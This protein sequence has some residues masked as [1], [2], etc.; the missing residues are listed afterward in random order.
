[1]LKIRFL[2]KKQRKLLFLANFKASVLIDRVF[3]D[4]GYVR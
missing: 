3:T 1:M 4:E 2:I